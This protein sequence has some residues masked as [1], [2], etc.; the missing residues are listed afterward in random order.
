MQGHGPSDRPAEPPLEGRRVVVTRARH[1]A[2][3]L[4]GALEALGADVV[5]F[6][7]IRIVGPEDP[8]PLRRAIQELDSYDWLI[9]TSRNGVRYFRDELERAGLAATDIRARVACVGR[10][11]AG[12]VEA[13]GVPVDLVP[14]DQVGEGLLESLLATGSVDGARILL[15]RAAVARDI[16]PDGLREHGAHVDDVETYRTVPDTEG[17]AAMRVEIDAGRIDALTFT[18]PSSVRYFVDVMGTSIGGAAVVAIGPVTGDAA[19]AVGL[20]V[21]AE[22]DDHSLAGLVRAVVSLWQPG[23]R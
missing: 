3:D 21:A 5:L 14:D 10:A 22:A 9:L 4:I 12:E 2:G 19:R 6:P 7:T 13:L 15:P 18:S 11:T 8:G 17:A 23:S 20:P 16:L 1:Q